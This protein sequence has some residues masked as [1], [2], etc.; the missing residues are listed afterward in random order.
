MFDFGISLFMLITIAL[1][2][3]LVV[4]LFRHCLCSVVI[5]LMFDFDI[6]LFMSIMCNTIIDMSLLNLHMHVIVKFSCVEY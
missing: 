4:F 1:Y 2:F 6:S 5:N 3:Y